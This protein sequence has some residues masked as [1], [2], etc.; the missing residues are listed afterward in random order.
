MRFICSHHQLLVAQDPLQ[1]YQQFEHLKLAGLMAMEAQSWELACRKLGAAYEIAVL[2]VQHQHEV[3]GASEMINNLLYSCHHLVI[4]LSVLGHW[5]LV[6]EYLRLLLQHCERLLGAQING[7]AQTLEEAV[8]VSFQRMKLLLVQ[9][10]DQR[11]AG[12]LEQLEEFIVMPGCR[13]LLH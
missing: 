13:V 5:S 12:V 8:K 2:A 1:A 10:R 9:N 11:M 6:S 7:D 4:C 3:V